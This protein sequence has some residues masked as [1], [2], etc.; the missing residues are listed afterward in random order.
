[1]NKVPYDMVTETN[2]Q[3]AILDCNNG[4]LI[5]EP[6]KKEI[7]KYK[8][9]YKSRIFDLGGFFRKKKTM[10]RQ[11]IKKE[12]LLWLISAMWMNVILL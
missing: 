2:G 9:L 10:L 6:D 11:L 4:T 3:A 8:D 7:S 1:M 5:I 12:Y